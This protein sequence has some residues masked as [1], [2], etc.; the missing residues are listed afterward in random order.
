[1]PKQRRT[2]LT[3]SAMMSRIHGT[4]TTPERVLRSATWAAGFQYRLNARVSGAR[5]DLLMPGARVAVFV[6]G[7]FW[8]GCP[9]HYVRPRNR[10]EF[11]GRKLA[12]NVDRD[13][14]HTLALEADGWRVLRFWECEVLE[15]VAA[16][17][18]A[19]SLA[20]AGRTRRALR[21]WRVYQATPAD[22]TGAFEYRLLVDLRS[23]EIRRTEL[24][25]RTTKKA[26]PAVGLR[27]VRPQAHR[28][29]V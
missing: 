10:A 13:R 2:S 14:Q 28:S 5:P 18:G 15:D 12:G 25:K 19:M 26:Q 7:C 11:W 6:D 17:V 21:S 9:K 4:D 29:T 24:C 16:C 3:R 20:I 8:H 27:A 22:P 1:M 23:A